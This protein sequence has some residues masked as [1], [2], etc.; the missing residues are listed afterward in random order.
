MN[1]TQFLK[2]K[3][4][5]KIGHKQFIIRFLEEET[6]INLAE[7]LEE[8]SNLKNPE[9]KKALKELEFI[10]SVLNGG[11]TDDTERISTIRAYLSL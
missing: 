6:T 5:I 10:E 4:I 11:K 8:Y 3:G 9:L 2:E 1:A 7:L